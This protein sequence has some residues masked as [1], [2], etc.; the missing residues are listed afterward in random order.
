MSIKNRNVFKVTL[1]SHLTLVRICTLYIWI[2]ENHKVHYYFLQYLSNLKVSTI[3]TKK[4]EEC[5]NP[6]KD[7]RRLCKKKKENHVSHQIIPKVL[8]TED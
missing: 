3:L 8:I 1:Y 6:L 2:E 4:D 7:E 5:L